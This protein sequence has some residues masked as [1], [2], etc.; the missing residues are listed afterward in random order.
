[1]RTQTHT[2]TDV[3]VWSLFECLA[4]LIFLQYY[5]TVYSEKLRAAFNQWKMFKFTPTVI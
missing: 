4:N 1:M 2:D 5:W 3:F